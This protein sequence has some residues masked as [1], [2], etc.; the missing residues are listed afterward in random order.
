MSNSLK[1]VKK[2][3]KCINKS[4]GV[5]GVK[6]LQTAAAVLLT[7]SYIVLLLAAAVLETKRQTQLN[8]SVCVDGL[9]SKDRTNIWSMRPYRCVL[10]AP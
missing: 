2:T 3:P 9:L 4:V 7:S 8:G 6:S 10:S 5:S 1:T